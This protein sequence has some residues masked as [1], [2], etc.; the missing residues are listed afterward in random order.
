MRN[1]VSILPKKQKIRASSLTV[2]YNRVLN[3]T[4]RKY[5]WAGEKCLTS[6]FMSCTVWKIR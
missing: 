6:S 1:F 5:K 2:N 4:G 3:T